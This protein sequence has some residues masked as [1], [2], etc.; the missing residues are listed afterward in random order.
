MPAAL[1]AAHLLN[2]M[3]SRQR[4]RLLTKADQIK[5]LLSNVAPATIQPEEADQLIDYVIDESVLLDEASMTMM[6]TNERDIRFLQL[7]GG[8]LRLADCST[9]DACTESASVTNTN[10]CLSTVDIDVAFFLCDNDL[11][12]NITGAQFQD[13]IMRM[14]ADAMANEL[15]L[16]ALMANMNGSYTTNAA[17]SPAVVNNAVMAA[18]EGWYRW[19]Q[20]GNIIDAASVGAGQ[21]G[22]QR[23][24]DFAKLNCLVTAVPT[25]FRRNP[26]A[27][28][29]YMPSDMKDRDWVALHQGRQTDLGD[30]AY[31]GATPQRH[32]ESPIVGVPLL[33]TDIQNCG[34]TSLPTATGTFMFFTEPGNMVWGVQQDITFTT[35]RACNHRTWLT[36][37]IRADAIIFNEEAT[38]LMD[39][40]Q[41]S[42]CGTG[43]CAPD[44]LTSTCNAC[45]NLGSG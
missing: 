44:A 45:L 7:S 32:G 38:S 30:T 40:M 14:T 15:E 4:G 39:C 36:W 20:Q 5:F 43:A 17:T 34:C 22:V 19:L 1:S 25:R 8:I 16:F 23:A 41:L 33:P 42:S 26:G 9:G 24:L 29:I 35:W 13:Q 2:N 28:R 18:T 27:M 37:K 10:K 12:D 11:M 31:L 6:D 3:G 21:G